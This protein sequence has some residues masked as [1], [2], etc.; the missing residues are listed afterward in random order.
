MSH[1][2][3]TRSQIES[4]KNLDDY[5]NFNDRQSVKNVQVVFCSPKG[6][7]DKYPWKTGENLLYMGD[8]HNMG[9]H[10]VFVDRSHRI[11]WG[12]HTDNFY[13]EPDEDATT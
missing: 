7:A 9:G 12:Y 4:W 2:Q 13:V 6:Y 10:G 8:V 5:L 1:K 11:W 3:A